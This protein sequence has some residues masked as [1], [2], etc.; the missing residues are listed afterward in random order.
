M[1]DYFTNV[2]EHPIEVFEP[3]GNFSV[4]GIYSILSKIDHCKFIQSWIDDSLSVQI[5]LVKNWLLFE[6][7]VIKFLRQ[8]E[9][10]KVSRF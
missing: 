5:K 7:F 4:F 1:G 2:I 6:F 10:H 9:N 8:R 3:S